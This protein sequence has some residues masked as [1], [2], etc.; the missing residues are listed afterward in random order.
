MS[1]IKNKNLKHESVCFKINSMGQGGVTGDKVGK[2]GKNQLIEVRAFHS[3][4]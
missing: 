3:D 4:I 1:K 2:V